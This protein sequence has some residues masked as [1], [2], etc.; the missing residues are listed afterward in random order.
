VRGINR[1][2][3]GGPL[4]GKVMESPASYDVRSA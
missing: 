2:A 1:F 4:F 3:D